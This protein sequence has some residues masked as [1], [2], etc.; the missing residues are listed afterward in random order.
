MRV[1][2]YARVSTNRQAL[3][4]SIEQQLVGCASMLSRK[5]SL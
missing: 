2:L 3:T 1:A 5:V 4:Q